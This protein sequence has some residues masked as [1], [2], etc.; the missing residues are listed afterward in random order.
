MTETGIRTAAALSEHPLATHAVGECV[1]QLLDIGGPSPDLV[2]LFVTAPQVGALED[3][4]PAVGGLLD[5]GVL[6]GA[7]AVSVLAGSREAEEHAALAAFGLWTDSRRSVRSVRLTAA[8]TPNGP[9]FRG[10][11]KLA[12]EA[13][14]LILVSD[15][16]SFPVEEVLDEL[17]VMAPELTVIG[18]MAS[19]A[20]QRGGNRLLLDGEL[21]SDGAVGVLLD[22]SVPVR[23]VVSQGCRP[24]GEP[25]TVT[26]A[27]RNIV[28]ELAGRPAL[29]RLLEQVERLDDA[30]RALAAKGL[31]IGRVIDEH[32]DVFE[33]GDFLVRG[34]VGADK[35]VGAIA[36][37]D[38]VDVGTT[39][40][41]QVRDAESADE[42]LRSMMADRSANGALV[43]TCNGRG[44]A[45]F[46][47]PDHDAAVIHEALGDA[48]VAGMFCAGEIGPIGGAN[49]VHGFTASVALIG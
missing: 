29:D 2:V 21:H 33:R 18:G 43:F 19:A 44:S 8:P 13:G 3:I 23:P 22:P 15:P 48:A 36:I 20:R 39:V 24:F 40:Q 31:H 7:S 9:E 41:F 49:F 45:L 16:F 35:A 47:T 6:V 11:D 38:S 26:R 28:Y 1:G 46:G 37:G 34:V 25:Q 4:S 32:R 27:E 42:D 14:T 12:G 30:D 10:I 5:P 17:A